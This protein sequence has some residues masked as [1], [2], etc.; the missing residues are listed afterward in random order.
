MTA[1]C[2]SGLAVD[3]P[4]FPCEWRYARAEVPAISRHNSAQRWHSASHRRISSSSRNVAQLFA[5]ASQISAQ[6]SHTRRCRMD[7]RSMKFALVAHIS[8]QSSNV[9]M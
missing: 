1:R 5:H 6:I 4:T 9:V 2:A 7:S 3:A 8:T